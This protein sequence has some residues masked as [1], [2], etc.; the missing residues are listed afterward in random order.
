MDY[1]KKRVE[2][3]WYFIYSVVLGMPQVAC[4]VV[5]LDCFC[6]MTFVDLGRYIIIIK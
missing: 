6:G 4:N 2:K 1:G 3:Q 5:S